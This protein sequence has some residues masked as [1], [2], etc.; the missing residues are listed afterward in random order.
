MRFIGDLEYHGLYTIVASL[1]S[2]LSRTG[3][4]RFIV[5][6]GAR[7]TTISVSDA[8]RLKID[9]NRRDPSLEPLVGIGGKADAFVLKNCTLL[10]TEIDSGKIY[11]E[12]LDN[13]Q[14][15]SPNIDDIEKRKIMMFI[16]SLLGIDVLA[17]YHISFTEM[18]VI[19]SM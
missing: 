17:K 4:I 16:P 13:V 5:D 12:E 9:Y 7:H 11:P 6:T 10:L 2:P 3:P 19:L 8:Q 14:V 1:K 18:S 15:V